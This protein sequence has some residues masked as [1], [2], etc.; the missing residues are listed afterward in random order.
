MRHVL[1]ITVVLAF[2]FSG[3][4][5]SAAQNLPYIAIG[6][7]KYKLTRTIRFDTRQWGTV[8]LTQ[9]FVSD[10]SS[11]PIPDN[12][13]TRMAGFF[14]DAMYTSSGHLRFLTRAHPRWWSKKMADREYCR[15]MFKLGANLYHRQLNCAGAKYGNHTRKAWKRYRGRRAKRW[16]Q[17]GGKW[18]QK[19]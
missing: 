3:W 15:L 7:G 11:S 13:A 5:P 10:G 6:N 12:H 9:G 2:I 17:R 19:K 1:H 14:H 18:T 16:A 8:A 4:A